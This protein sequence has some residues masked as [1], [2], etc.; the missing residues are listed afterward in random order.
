MNES[1]SLNYNWKFHFGEIQTPK[2]L[3]K[4]SYALGGLTAPLENETG[5]ILPIGPGGSH[6]LNLISNGDAKEGLKSLAGTDFVKSL[7][8]TW[9]TLNLPDDWKRREPYQNDLNNLMTGSKLDGIAYYRKTF[10]LPKELQQEDK[11][12]LLHFDGIMGSSDV[13]F[14]GCYLG[15]NESGYVAI[16]YDISPIIK[17]TNDDNVVLVRT[18]TTTGSEGWW[19]EGAGIYKNAWIEVKDLVHLESDEFYFRTM[20]I[21]DQS[22]KMMVNFV[23]KNDLNHPVSVR[24]KIKINQTIQID[25]ETVTIQSQSERQFNKIFEIKAPKLWTPEQP[26]LYQAKLEIENDFLEQNFGIKTVSYDVTGFHLNGRLYLLK[27]VCEHQDFGGVGVAL[28]QDIIDFKV[29]RLKEMGVNAL[30]SSHHFASEEL[31]NACDRMGIILIDENRLLEATPWRLK[32][33]TKMVKKSRCHVSIS[34]WSIANEEIIGNTEYGCRS[35]KKITEIIR[36]LSPDTLLI[37][38]E[39]LNPE[40][41][42][43]DDYLKYFDILGVNYPEAGV[44]GKGAE[45]I[46]QSHPNLPMMCTENASYFSTRGIYKDDAVNCHTNNFGSLYSMVL[47]GKRKLGDPGVGGTA[48]PE[49]VMSYIHEHEYMGGVFLWTAFDYY[50][51]PSPFGWPGISSQFGIMDLCGLPKDYFYYYQAQ[52]QNQPVLHLMPSWNKTDLTIE[53]G[54][55]NVRVF[56][57]LDEVELFINHKS[58]GKKIVINYECN[59]QV[60]YE[61][62]ELLARGYLKDKVLLEDKKETSDKIS[63]V[64]TDVLYQGKN[65]TLFILEAIDGQ[66]NF[67]PDDNS[68]LQV[69]AENGQIIGLA[70]GN[71]SDT[72]GYS[73]SKIKLFS[74][75]AVVIVKHEKNVLPQVNVD[76]N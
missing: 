58:L 12:Y 56:S 48:N 66:S 20:E 63:K 23:V 57:N 25:F 4:K 28:N 71:P 50:G 3:A 14:N 69:T 42:V 60:E 34:F 62:G 55:T 68:S 46:H 53:N 67:V 26:N 70:N 38:A 43:N 36:S 15:H 5:S 37:S 45:L 52:W 41:K 74:G 72:N 54:Q 10:K 40:G 51:E 59:W 8:K 75:K 22:A 39:L 13:W 17:F 64:H 30:R 16:D 6:F 24:P 11:E 35:V 31:L 73:L 2:L 44:M 65:C 1:I 47:P 32:N 7:D 33:L 21:N 19:Y 61:P 29:R 76:F 18:D 27:G 9:Q 49:T